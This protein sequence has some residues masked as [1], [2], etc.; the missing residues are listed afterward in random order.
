M[1][2]PLDITTSA[3]RLGD[4]TVRQGLIKRRGRYRARKSQ[5]RAHAI[6]I[7]RDRFLQR[8]YSLAAARSHCPAT[9]FRDRRLPV[10]QKALCNREAITGVT[11]LERTP[12]SILYNT[13]PCANAMPAMA[14]I[15]TIRFN[16]IHCSGIDGH[17]F[18]LARW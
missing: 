17:V 12:V 15:R 13:T 1:F 9:F 4:V 6:V 11:S 18:R 8:V 7:S 10:H 5:S 2:A 16:I 14:P 3:P